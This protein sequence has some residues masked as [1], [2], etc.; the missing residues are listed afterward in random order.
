MFLEVFVIFVGFFVVGFHCFDTFLEVSECF[1]L[2]LVV[3]GSVW[4]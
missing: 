2:V 3:H 1:F 4:C